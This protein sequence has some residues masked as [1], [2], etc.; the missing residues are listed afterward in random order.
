MVY[1]SIS[2][3]LDLAGLQW[4]ALKGHGQLFLATWLMKI[5]FKKKLVDEFSF[6][7]KA[8]E[9][10]LIHSTWE[11]NLLLSVIWFV[12]LNDTIVVLLINSCMQS[13]I[14]AMLIGFHS[15]HIEDLGFFCTD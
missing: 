3:F 14:K 5:A 15:I 6:E 13:L 9:N 11:C 4:K 10:L 12:L 8:D 7:G 1:N 2:V